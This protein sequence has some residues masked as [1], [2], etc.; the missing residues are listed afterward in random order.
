MERERRWENWT[1]ISFLWGSTLTFLEMASGHN[2]VG[3]EPADTGPELYR[4]QSRETW[5]IKMKDIV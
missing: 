5:D 2:E 4:Y 1:Y 3:D